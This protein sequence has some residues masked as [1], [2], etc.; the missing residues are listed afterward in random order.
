MHLAFVSVTVKDMERALDFYSEVFQQEPDRRNEW[1]SWF[2][3]GNVRFS[4]YNPESE[5]KDI[6]FGENCVAAFRVDD[7]EATHDRLQ[8]LAPDVEDIT[9]GDGYQLFHFTDT[10]GNLVEVFAGE[11]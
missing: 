3:L 5:G 7:I 4:L 2:D 11:K 9:G 8:Q 1:L 10:E 6:T